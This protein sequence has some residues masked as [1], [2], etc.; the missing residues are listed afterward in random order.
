MLATSR[1][2][3]QQIPFH[4]VSPSSGHNSYSSVKPATK[5][6][7]V[8]G[9]VVVTATLQ[10]PLMKVRAEKPTFPYFTEGIDVVAGYNSRSWTKKNELEGKTGGKKWGIRE[11][12]KFKG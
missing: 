8:K 10:D 9:T 3:C 2:Q 11:K 6:S 5:L 4:Y 1:S 12:W 7:V